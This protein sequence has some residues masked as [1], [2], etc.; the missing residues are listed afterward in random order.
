[1]VYIRRFWCFAWLLCAGSAWS[2]VVFVEDFQDGD[3]E[4]WR[5]EGRGDY[6]LTHYGTNYSFRLTN[7][8]AAVYEVTAHGLSRLGI[9]IEVAADQLEPGDR[10]VGEVSLDGGKR[11]ESVISVEDGMDD[12]VTMHQGHLVVGAGE[13]PASSMLLRLRAEGEG[14]LGGERRPR[15]PDFDFCWFDN[16]RIEG[17]N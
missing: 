7:R 17:L 11:W 3:A 2:S 15:R 14:N 5:M 10:C 12:G 8:K 1:M 4:G 16:I 9:G 13:A 6:M